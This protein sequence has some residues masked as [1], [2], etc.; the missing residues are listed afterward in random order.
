MTDE[1]KDQDEEITNPLYGKFTEVNKALVKQTE[2]EIKYR[3]PMPDE[4]EKTDP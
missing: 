4:E 3:R 1:E 2:R